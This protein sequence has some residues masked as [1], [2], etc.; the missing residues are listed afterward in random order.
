MK[1]K[2]MYLAIGVGIGVW[3]VPKFPIKFPGL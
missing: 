2:W 3:V 1:S